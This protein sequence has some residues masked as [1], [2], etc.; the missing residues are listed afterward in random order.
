MAVLLTGATGFVGLNIARALLD[1]TIA[2]QACDEPPAA[3]HLIDRIRGF[4]DIAG[5]HGGRTTKVEHRPLP[6]SADP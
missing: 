2:A 6:S 1:R 4:F 3:V 5:G